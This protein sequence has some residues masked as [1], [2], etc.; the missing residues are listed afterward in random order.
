MKIE[1]II[2]KQYSKDYKENLDHMLFLRAAIDRNL[3]GKVDPE[4]DAIPKYANIIPQLRKRSQAQKKHDTSYV[5]RQQIESRRSYFN[6]VVLA[7]DGGESGKVL[8]EYV[9]HLSR[10]GFDIADKD[11][12]SDFIEAVQDMDGE[13]TSI[14]DFADSCAWELLGMGKCYVLTLPHP[15]GHPKE[16]TPYSQIIKREDV[17]DMAY[18]NGQFKY[19]KYK[20]EH[21]AFEGDGGLERYETEKIVLITK[22]EYITAWYNDKGKMTIQSR[23]TNALGVVTVAEAWLGHGANSII[24]SVATLQFV[25]MNAESVLSQKIR[26]QAMNILCVPDGASDIDSQIQSLS[27]SIYIKEPNGSKDTR[28]AGYPSSGLDGDF[29]Y[30]EWNVRRVSDLASLRYKDSTSTQTSGYSKAWDFM[31]TDAVLQIAATGVEDVINQTIGFWMMILGQS[32]VG[33]VFTMK[34]EFQP[35]D[36]LQTLQI[37]LQAIGI[38][39]GETAEK[40]LKRLTRD[41]LRQIGLNL[42]EEDRAKSDQEIEQAMVSPVVNDILTASGMPAE[43]MDTENN[44]DTTE[45]QN[46]D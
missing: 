15:A 9:G 28:W 17:L 1:D 44:E 18:E 32:D 3:R 19:F 31:D 6:R 23:E 45:P 35:K 43:P 21:C 16:G 41:S 8:R 5:V 36:L 37:I 11:L 10:G 7:V 33:K 2:E 38:G 4:E 46:E 42:S 14:K 39:V 12:P 40:G 29:K 13:H 27:A 30:I 34:R 20:A 26:Q 24:D 25:T 22:E